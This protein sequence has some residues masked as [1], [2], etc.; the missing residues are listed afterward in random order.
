MTDDPRVIAGAR[1]SCALVNDCAKCTRPCGVIVHHQ[2][3]VAVILAAADAVARP[4]E[5]L[6]E[7][8]MDAL[9][10]YTQPIAEPERSRRLLR[11]MRALDAWT[12]RVHGHHG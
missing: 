2:R 1:V 8:A 12:V 4:D 5:E 3:A 7:L 10:A 6:L 11:A 9:K